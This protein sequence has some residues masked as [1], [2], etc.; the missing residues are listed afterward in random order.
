MLFSFI[1]NRAQPCQSLFV[2]PC[3]HTWHYKCIRVIINGP[4]WP[5][6]I[7]PNC[8]TVAD[9]EA[10]LDDPFADGEWEELEV[11][12]ATEDREARE[13]T[14]APEETPVASRPARQA[15]SSEAT[16]APVPPPKDDP[17]QEQSVPSDAEVAEASDA[18]EP[19]QDVHEVATAMGYLNVEDPPS[20]PSSSSSQ[21]HVSNATVQPV[22]IIGRKP[23]PNCTS[24]RLGE[25]SAHSERGL[26][27]TPS[28]NG[29]HPSSMDAVTGVEGPM[30]PR[31]DAGPF[32]FD[33]SAGRAAGMRL[34]NVANMNLDEAA[35]TPIPSA[36]PQPQATTEP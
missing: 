33:G 20:P 26:T 18:S 3:S 24:S 7:C 13:T 6:F 32:I 5:H 16:Q 2:A 17:D 34:A 11:A 31:N 22:D 28:P 4:H 9:L 10:E 35:D 1:T 36:T 14:A 21:P 30:T 25:P 29:L 27:R 15:N 23:V 12:E 8:R 19:D